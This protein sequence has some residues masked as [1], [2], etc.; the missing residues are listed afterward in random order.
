MLGSVAGLNGSIEVDPSAATTVASSPP[1]QG[2]A[3]IP[4]RHNHFVAWVGAGTLTRVDRTVGAGEV[5]GGDGGDAVRGG[6]PDVHAAR[7]RRRSEQTIVPTRRDTASHAL[8]NGIGEAAQL[9]RRVADLRG[10]G[11]IEASRGR[12]LAQH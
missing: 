5:D 4:G 3:A 12:A 7:I 2:F 8:R 9:L 6:L 11:R 1:S 10:T